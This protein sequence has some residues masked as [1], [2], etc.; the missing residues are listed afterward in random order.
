[1]TLLNKVF[2]DGIARDLI[3]G[4]EIDWS[5]DGELV[6][7]SYQAPSEFILNLI[8]LKEKISQIEVHLG[9]IGVTYISLTHWGKIGS[10]IDFGVEN[11]PRGKGTIEHLDSENKDLLQIGIPCP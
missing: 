11:G 9:R 6:L 10:E 7:R 1:M 3:S 8:L 2:P 5:K 4:G